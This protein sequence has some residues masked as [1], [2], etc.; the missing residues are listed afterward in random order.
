MITA[1]K[2][3]RINRAVE[4]KNIPL[5]SIQNRISLQLS[6]NKKKK[7]AD[8][9]I[10]NDSNLSKFVKKIDKIYLKLLQ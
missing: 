4:R 3:I 1:K 6:D 7:I 9:I 10:Q 8:Y 2:D 5:E